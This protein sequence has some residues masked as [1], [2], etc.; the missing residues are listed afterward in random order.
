MGYTEED[1]A[2]V[3]EAIKKLCSGARVANVKIG[4]ISLTYS[5]STLSELMELKRIME[6][7]LLRKPKVLM[8]TTGKGL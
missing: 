2:A 1:L 8:A 6:Y 3:Q 7:E 5:R 4:E